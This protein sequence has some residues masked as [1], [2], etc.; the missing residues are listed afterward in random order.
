MN[1][2]FLIDTTSASSGQ[3]A[4]KSMCISHQFPPYELKNEGSAKELT[5]ASLPKKCSERPLLVIFFTV[6]GTVE[7]L[8]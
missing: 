3:L 7:L 1:C 5:Q 4:D 2:V 8:I 6:S